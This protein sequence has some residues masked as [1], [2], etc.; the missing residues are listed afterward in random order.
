MGAPDI[1][2]ALGIDRLGAGIGSIR[3]SSA[4]FNFRFAHRLQQRSGLPW[5]GQGALIVEKF[6]GVAF[7]N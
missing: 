7:Q 4:V 5:V 2:W 3:L 1:G 6:A